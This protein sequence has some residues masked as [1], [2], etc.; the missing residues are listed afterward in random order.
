VRNIL[1][2]EGFRLLKAA[3]Y[4]GN[5]AVHLASVGP[6]TE[7]LREL[8]T[9]GASVHVR[10]R[11]DNTP[12]FLAEKSGRSDN[13]KLLKEAGAHLWETETAGR[14]TSVQTSSSV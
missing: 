12:L 11:A 2:G 8:L 6:D 7:V 10:N 14:T 1:E 4:A 3:D 13:V 9:R 5:T